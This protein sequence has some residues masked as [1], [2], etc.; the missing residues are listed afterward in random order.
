MPNWG[1]GGRRERGFG[2]RAKSSARARGQGGDPNPNTI[3]QRPIK[4]VHAELPFSPGTF[5]RIAACSETV[6][7]RWH[8]IESA[9]PANGTTAARFS[10]ALS[11][12]RLQ[13]GA[14]GCGQITSLTRFIGE[15]SNIFGN[16]QKKNLRSNP[17]TP[18][19]ASGLSDL[20]SAS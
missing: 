4:K 9:L 10:G 14:G 15:C 18:P 1:F 20:G 17:S 11:T 7:E 8:C 6:Y 3:S 19:R 13:E 16:E 12:S 5:G 2:S